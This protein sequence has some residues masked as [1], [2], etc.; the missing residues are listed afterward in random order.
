MD[1]DGCKMDELRGLRLKLKGPGWTDFL[2]RCL[3][4]LMGLQGAQSRVTPRKLCLIVQTQMLIGLFVMV[5]RFTGAFWF[6]MVTI[7]EGEDMQSN[8]RVD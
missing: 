2:V 5:A 7:R 3:R 4:A 8:D 6:Q 1:Q